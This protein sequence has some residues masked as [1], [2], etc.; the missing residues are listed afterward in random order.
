MHGL[1]L[2]HVSEA[3]IVVGYKSSLIRD[4]VGLSFDGIKITYVDACDYET[5]NNM[6]SLWDARDYLTEDVILVEADVIFDSNLITDLLREKGSSAAVSP[7]N[8]ALS[9][10]L[11]KCDDQFRITKFI[12]NEDLDR[13][14]KGIDL[15]KTVNLYLF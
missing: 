13:L 3:V 6:R 14:S 5:T 1:S 11:I 8:K 9:G 12:M 10:T 4:R 2:Q 15:F 7:N